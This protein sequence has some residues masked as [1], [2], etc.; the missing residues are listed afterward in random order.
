M[1]ML[2]TISVLVTFL[3][4]GGKISDTLKAVSAH[5]HALSLGS[6]QQTIQEATVDKC[7]DTNFQGLLR[8]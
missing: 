4:G 3:N 5:A 7:N 8:T 6:G 2:T 1:Q